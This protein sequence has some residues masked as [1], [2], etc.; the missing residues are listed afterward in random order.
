[1][2][3]TPLRRRS[4]T[5]R[6]EAVFQ[7]RVALLHKRIPL[8]QI[9]KRERVSVQAIASFFHR[10]GLGDVLM[11]NRRRRTRDVYAERLKKASP[12][13]QFCGMDLYKILLEDT[14][15]YYVNKYCST[16]CRNDAMRRMALKRDKSGA[17]PLKGKVYYQRRKRG[18]TW[19]EVG[20]EYGVTA[21]G[22]ML[23]AKSYAKIRGM[24]WPLSVMKGKRR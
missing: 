9:A 19:L 20:Q 12:K 18:H 5:A 15:R 10:V 3:R 2:K 21:I 17:S 13:C 4:M 23:V 14:P 16:Q 24:P 8:E 7:R 6:S 22:A 11:Q 1:M